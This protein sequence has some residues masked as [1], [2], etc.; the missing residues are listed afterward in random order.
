MD[1]RRDT[2]RDT[3][4]Q[5]GKSFDPRPHLRRVQTQGQEA[6]YL[7]VKWRLAW[8]R[9]EHPDAR[10]T[11]DLATL[12]EALAI[13]RATIEIPSGGSATGYGS[14]MKTDFPDYIEKAET[15]AVGRALA[16]LGYGTQFALELDRGNPVLD[17]DLPSSGPAEPSDRHQGR[18]PLRLAPRP[19]PEPESEPEVER[20]AEP[21]PVPAR[22]ASKGS[23]AT[24]PEPQPRSDEGYNPANFSWNEF[25]HWARGL[26]YSSKSQLEGLL[27]HPLGEMTPREVRAELL[28]YRR[29]Q[30][31]PG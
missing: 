14:E 21:S 28:A 29:E 19:E 18:S 3:V 15:R 4:R 24:A 27:G 11:T 7:D 10:I 31:L 8:L 26:G 23:S 30:G 22:P 16:A 2:E 9:A 25:W 6:D 17:L 12:N 13:F 5:P 1:G 20:K